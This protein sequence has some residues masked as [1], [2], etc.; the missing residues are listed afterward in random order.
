ML[1]SK[2]KNISTYSK[3]QVRLLSYDYAIIHKENGDG[4]EKQI[5]QIRHK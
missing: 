4:N 5:T 3:E 2:S 1:S